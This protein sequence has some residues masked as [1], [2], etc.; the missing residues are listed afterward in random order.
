[1]AFCGIAILQCVKDYDWGLAVLDAAVASNPNDLVAA[2][3]A[4]TGH[5]HCGSLDTALGLYRRALRLNPHNT[6]AHV[7]LCGIAHVQIVQGDHA[8]AVESAARAL[9]LNPNY[10]PTHWMLVAANAHLGRL[11]E[12]RRF[13]GGLLRM[14]PRVTIAGIRAGQPAKDPSRIEPVLDGL[15]L[16]G[17]DPG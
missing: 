14:T 7:S 6:F 3:A 5:L 10:D 2:G 15:R 4:A 1:M 11:D 9:A 17:L 16:A 13:L 12:A 8:E